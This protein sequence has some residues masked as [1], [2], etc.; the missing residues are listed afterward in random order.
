MCPISAY[1]LK[2]QVEYS[3]RSEPPFDALLIEPLVFKHWPLWPN[4]PPHISADA[5]IEPKPRAK[6][7]AKPPDA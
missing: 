5:V 7:R 2:L 3:D 1:Q 6:P 4:K